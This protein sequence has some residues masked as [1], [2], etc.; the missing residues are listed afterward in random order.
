[1]AGLTERE[2]MYCK[3]EE[4]GKVRCL[5]CPQVCELSVG[6][7]GLCRGR[8]NLGGKM[9]AVNYGQSI[10]AS[11]DPIEK[12][13]LYHFRPGSRIV[14]LGPNSCNLACFFCQNWDSS[15]QRCPTRF[16]SPAELYGL[17][18]EQ[19]QGGPR[20]V[21]FTYTEPF[22]WYEYIW[23]FAELATDADIV[24]VTNGFVNP[25]P[26]EALLPRVKAMNVDLKSIRDDFYKERCGGRLEPVLHTIRRAYESKVHL[27]VTNLLIPGLNDSERDIAD[28]VAFV[29]SV[30]KDIPLHFSAYRPAYKSEIPATPP[31]TVLKACEAAAKSLDYVYA[32]NLWQGGFSATH[33]P[34]CHDE[35]ISASRRLTGIDGQG[36]CV[37]CGHRIYGVF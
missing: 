1:M 6:Q 34:A 31:A 17:V 11:F 24:L 36:N 3:A 7:S 8:K 4:G 23:D 19:A 15:Q 20:Q 33:C 5:L 2:A 27:E 32:G 28:L 35:V 18:Q 21:A 30:G 14:S 16:I 26:L 10:G 29:A 37:H 12:K 13:P 9:V 22:T 25:E